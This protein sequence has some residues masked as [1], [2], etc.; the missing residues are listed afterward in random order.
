MDA[1]IVRR[2]VSLLVL[3][4]ELH[5]VAHVHKSHVKL[6]RSLRNYG[7]LASELCHDYSFLPH[8]DGENL[9]C[10]RTSISESFT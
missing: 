4:K 1:V 6:I 9:H 10:L 8:V 2:N 7:L 3:R 5:E